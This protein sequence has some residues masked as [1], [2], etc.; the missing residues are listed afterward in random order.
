MAKIVF[1]QGLE[2]VSVQQ[3]VARAGVTRRTFYELFESR[4]DCFRAVFEQSVAIAAERVHLLGR[5]RRR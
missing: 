3:I 5:T 1:E 2:S 4:E